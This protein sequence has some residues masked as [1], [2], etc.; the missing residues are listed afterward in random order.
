[1]TLEDRFLVR[2][3]IKTIGV[4]GMGYVGIPAAV[5]FAASGRFRHVIGLQRVSPR[6]GH[7]IGLLNEG[8][9][10][11]GG[12]EPE[13]DRLLLEVVR[14]GTFTATGDFAGISE[15]DAITIAIQTPFAD[16]VRLTPDY[17]ALFE[18]IGEV[19]KNLTDGSIVVIEST[20]T[21]GTTEGPARRI[22]ERESGLRAGIEFGLAHAPER[23]MPGRLV[24]NIRE[25]DRVVG[26]IDPASTTRAIELYTPVLTEASIIAMSAKAAEVTK[27]AE[28]ALRDLQIAAINELALYCE[29]IGVN[30]YDV[31]RGIA[32]LRGEGITRAILTPGAGVG[33]HCLTKDSYHLELGVRNSERELDFPRGRESLFTLARGINDF[34]PVHMA[35]LTESGL[36][37]IGKNPRGSHIA[38]LGWAFIGNSGDSR[39][40][41]SEPFA[42]IM[43]EM[44]AEIT[45]HDP[46]VRS[47]P[48][49]EISGNLGVTLTGADAIVLFTAHNEYRCLEPSELKRL[50]GAVHPVVVDGRNLIDPDLF[51]ASGFVYKGIGRGD[52]ND[53]ELVGPGSGLC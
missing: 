29:A 6:S 5:T 8:R 21:P 47:F 15:C 49:R 17:S 46:H 28:N 26:G 9:N 1:M 25:H 35:G 33:G 2:G 51:I 4:V 41:P 53:H 3:P 20:V 38:L 18:G 36:A 12:D 45:V 22:L 27:T 19:G 32:S 14:G 50:S 11:L 31:R 48:G 10:P 42:K 34:M 43:E 30:V 40:T 7:K 16:P 37:R 24:R 39:N 52:R 44:G 13:L 23:V